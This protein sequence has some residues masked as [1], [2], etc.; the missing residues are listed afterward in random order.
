MAAHIF[1]GRIRKISTDDSD[2]YFMHIDENGEVSFR[3]DGKTISTRKGTKKNPISVLDPAGNSIV[4]WEGFDKN[5]PELF[6]QKLKQKRFKT[7]E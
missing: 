3:A 1:F 2:I 5:K 4:I 6:L 7:L